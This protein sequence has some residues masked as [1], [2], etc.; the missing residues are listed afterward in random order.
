M[1]QKIPVIFCV[2]VEPD[3]FFVNRDAPEPWV[4]YEFTQRYLSRFRSTIEQATGAQVHYTWCFRMDPQVSKS[5]GTATWA[6]DRYP[7]FIHEI[8]RHGD[9]RGIHSHAHRWIQ[10]KQTWIEDFG[11]QDWVDHC[12]GTSF[13]AYAKAFGHPCKTFRFGAFW[14]NNATVNLVER[15]GAR[16]DLT[17]EPGRPRKT[18]ASPGMPEI[19]DPLPDFY[20][21]PRMPYVPS[22][23]DFR[24]PGIVGSR[25][26]TMI[27]ITSAPLRFG[28]HLRARFRHL[29]NNGFRNYH[30]QDTPLS[31][32]KA[33]KA[34]NTFEELLDR[35]ISAQAQPYLAFAIRTDI[36]VKKWALEAVE[37]SLRALLAH[38][39][40][41]RFQFCNPSEAL[42]ILANEACPSENVGTTF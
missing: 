7:E 28:V 9:E 21:V 35:A 3:P 12:V 11:N 15:L 20:R 16:F 10:E 8:E 23:S 19:T 2:D 25:S 29:C 1:N 38:P 14:L 13:E 22:E 41:N 39:E 24:K 30:F 5:Y 17:V 36:G 40:C 34:P 6:I 31:M 18:S 37:S 27:P 26:I 32:W 33:W 4:G 42:A